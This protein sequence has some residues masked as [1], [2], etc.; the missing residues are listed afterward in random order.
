MA[1]NP[2]NVAYP[3]SGTKR[4]PPLVILRVLGFMGFKKKE[5][6]P[7]LD[8][9]IQCDYATRD[10]V[11]ERV[12]VANTLSTYF[13]VIM[14]THGRK[15]DEAEPTPPSRDPRDVETIERLQQ[16]IQELEL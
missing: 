12:N 3:L 9:L 6:V 8:P 15:K 5:G 16:Q 11:N 10:T 1:K 14:Y 2:H 13:A 7:V 4:S